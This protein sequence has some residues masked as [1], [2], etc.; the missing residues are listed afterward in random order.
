MGRKRRKE[1]DTK[2]EGQGERKVNKT[3]GDFLMKIKTSCQNKINKIQALQIKMPM[4]RTLGD[5]D[6][7]QHTGEN[8][9][10]SD[11]EGM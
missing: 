6:G 10:P 4:E 11:S 5:E 7:A 9:L 2:G 3:G 8:T 1:A